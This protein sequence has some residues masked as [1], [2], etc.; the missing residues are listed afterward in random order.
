MQANL[1]A[2]ELALEQRRHLIDE[3]KSQGSPAPQELLDRID[4]NDRRILE[5]REALLAEGY[6]DLPE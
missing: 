2:L 6:R 5:L 4:E 1:A 3:W